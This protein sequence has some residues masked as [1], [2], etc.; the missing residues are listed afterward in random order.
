MQS[1]RHPVGKAL[2]VYSQ[3]PWPMNLIQE[4]QAC[5]LHVF[6]DDTPVL[7]N[8][9]A[10]VT[11][12]QAEVQTFIVTPAATAVSGKDMMLNPLNCGKI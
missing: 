10:I 12:P 11:N 4:S 1:F 3:N 7:M 5:R 9:A 2:L 8:R 6:Q